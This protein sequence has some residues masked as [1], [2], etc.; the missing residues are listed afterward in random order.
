M[1]FLCSPPGCLQYN[2]LSFREKWQSRDVLLLLISIRN[3]HQNPDT[4]TL[5]AAAYGSTFLAHWNYTSSVSS[6][7]G[8]MLFYLLLV[9]AGICVAFVFETWRYLCICGKLNSVAWD[10]RAGSVCKP[11]HLVIAHQSNELCTLHFSTLPYNFHI[12]RLRHGCDLVSEKFCPLYQ[13]GFSCCCLN[14]IGCVSEQ[15]QRFSVIESR[16]STAQSLTLR[17]VG[18]VCWQQK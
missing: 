6:L 5:V 10:K 3:F 9:S 2:W 13:R 15:L 8:E 17:W 1:W 7:T 4:V 12:L 14:A 11:F 18:F 16:W